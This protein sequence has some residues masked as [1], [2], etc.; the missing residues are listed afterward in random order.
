MAIIQL[1]TLNHKQSCPSQDKLKGLVHLNVLM[2]NQPPQRLL[3][4]DQ[5]VVLDLHNIT[6]ANP[7]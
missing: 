5:A 7:N 1:V 2:K 4:K 3:L 6:L